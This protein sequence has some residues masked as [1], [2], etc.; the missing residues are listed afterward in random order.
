MPGL[1]LPTDRNGQLWVH[2]APHD[3]ARYVSAKDVLEG[4]V[5]A[6]PRLPQAGADRHLGGRP[7]RHQDD[8]DRSGHAG[9]RGARA[10][11]G[12]HSDQIACCRS[13]TT[14][15][16]AELLAAFVL[17]V[18]IIWLAPILG[19]GRCCCCSAPRSSR[20]WS[21]HPGT[22]S[23]QQRLLIDFTFPLLSSLLIYLTLVF[24]NYL[25]R[26]GAAPP[27][28]LGLRP[29]SVAD[30]GRA[31]RAVAGEARARRRGARHDDHVQRRA[32]LHHHFGNLQGRSARPDRADEQLPDAAD[33]RHHRPQGHDRQIHGRRH[34]GVLERA[35]RR[36]G[37]RAQC[38]RGGARH[39]RPRRTPQ[40]RTRGRRP[41]PAAQPFIP[42][43]I[44]VG[45]NTGTLRRRQ[46]GLRPALRLFGAGRQRESRLAAGRPVASPTAL[47]II[48]GS[49]DRDTSPR[50]SSRC[51]NSI[52]SR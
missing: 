46:H 12:K 25:P 35:A 52:S 48:I 5:A 20:C 22:S 31:A 27:H 3:Q 18:A 51:W 49:R 19:A 38:L 28:P 7:A 42:I 16:G 43:K 1:E 33:Q 6:G 37:A 39:A 47:P 4:R 21:A 26:A 32:R 29:V 14:P 40:P 45:I 15:I 36:P 50:T 34:H 23:P 2:F 11:S 41:R 13:R 24:I 9:R 17:G 10:G 44:G 8:A 30:A